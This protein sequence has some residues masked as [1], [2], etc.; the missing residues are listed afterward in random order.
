[1]EYEGEYRFLFIFFHISCLLVHTVISHMCMP[2]P[3]P[4]LAI[5]TSPCVPFVSMR[6]GGCSHAVQ[7]RSFGFD[8]VGSSS[9]FPI[10]LSLAWALV[11]RRHQ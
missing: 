5:E 11:S 4:N 9:K 3:R 7:I 6:I 10:P 8:W 1:M 2:H